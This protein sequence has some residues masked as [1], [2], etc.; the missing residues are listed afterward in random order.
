MQALPAGA[1][2]AVPLPAAEIAT[3][4]G[5]GLSH[6]AVN[7]PARAVVS[8]PEA[9]IAAL[10][11]ELARRGTPGKRLHTTRAFHSGMIDPVLASFAERVRAVRRSAPE[12]PF[13]S[14]LTGTWITAGEAVDP[15]Y[16]ARHLRGAVRFH[17]GLRTLAADS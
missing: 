9:E 2:L 5:P 11:A 13:A 6:A 1:M 7:G 3:L 16:W 14:N 8:G 10:E 15:G 17:D 4:L 12:L